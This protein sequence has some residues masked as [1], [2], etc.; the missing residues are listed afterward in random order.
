MKSRVTKLQSMRSR[1]P[2]SGLIGIIRTGI[3]GFSERMNA[4]DERPNEVL[5]TPP[6]QNH[7]ELEVIRRKIKK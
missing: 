2:E 5:S 4:V 3:R 1:D 7:P 6:V